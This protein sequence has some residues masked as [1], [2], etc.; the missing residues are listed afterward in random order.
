MQ[1]VLQS[2]PP[3]VGPDMSERR[4]DIRG[5]QGPPIRF[6]VE[7]GIDPTWKFQIGRVQIDA[8]G[9]AMVGHRVDDGLGQIA[10]GIEKRQ[11]SSSRQVGEDEGQN[12]RGLAG[13]GLAD[14]VEVS[15]SV[16]LAEIDRARKIK[17]R[18]PGTKI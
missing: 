15:T 9:N 16:V 5:D 11:A 6:D 4:H 3:A 10:M 12:E 18:S 13:A 1:Q 8:I 17:A 7:K 14:N 2:W